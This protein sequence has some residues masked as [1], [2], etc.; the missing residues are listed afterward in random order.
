SVFNTWI[1]SEDARIVED[2]SH[3]SQIFHP[4]AHAEEHTR[5]KR[6]ADEA[7]RFASGN[8][9]TRACDRPGYTGQYCEFPICESFNPVCNPEQ[10]LGDDGYVVDLTDLGNCTD[11]HKIIVDETMFDIRIEVQSLDNVSPKLTIIDDNGYIGTPDQSIQEDDRYVAV[12][13]FIPAGPYT[14]QSSASSNNSRCILTTTAQTT[15]TISGGFQTDERDRSDFPEETAAAHQFNS[16]LLTLHGTRAPAALKTVSVVGPENYVLRPRVLNKRYGC[17]HEFYFDSL[18]CYS[19]GSYA[20]I[21]EGVDF[22]GNLFRRVAPFECVNKPLSTT[23]L[24]P[25]TPQPTNPSSCANGGVLLESGGTTTCICQDHWSGYDCSQALCV[26]G[27]TRLAGKC[28]CPIGFEEVHCEQVKCEPNSEHGFGVDRPTLVFVVRVNVHQNDILKQVQQ[29]IDEVVASLQFDP[30]YLSRFRLVIF[31]AHKIRLSR[32]YSSVNDFDWDFENQAT[33]SNDRFGQCEDG[34]LG[35][36]AAAL[37][38]TSLTQGSMI[39]VI[40]D[41]LTDDYKAQIDGIIQMN[42]FARATINFLHID[43]EASEKCEKF[44]LSDPGFRAFEDVAN[45]FGGLAWHVTD[46]KRVYD[47]L[48][49]HLNSIIYRSQ[50]ML[51]L[52][53]EE[54]GKG[55]GKVMQIESN[56]E[57][58][59]FVFTGRDFRLEMKD[60]EGMIIKP[61]TVVNEGIFTVLSWDTPLAGTY[62]ITATSDTPTA[63]CSLRAYQASPQEITHNPQTEAY[64]AISTGVEADAMMY[65]P[66]AGTENHPVF[67]IEDFGDDVDSAF[68]FLNMYAVRNGVEQEVYASNGLFRGGCTFQ[69]YFPSF[70]CRP[71]EN[72]HYEFNIRNK[73]GFYVQRAGVMTCFNYVPTPSAPT[74]CQNGGVKHNGTCLCLAHYEGEHCQ[75]LICDNGGTPLFST[76]K[77]PVGWTGQF[78][79]LPQCPECGPLPSHG[80]HVDMAF[81][82]EVSQKGVKQIEQLL[83]ILPDIIRDVVSQHPDWIDRLVLIGYDSKGVVGMVDSLISNT[84]NFFDALYTWSTSNPKDDEC[85]VQIWKAIDTLLN[86]RKDGNERR[87][88]PERS[89]V[90]II[91]ASVPNGDGDNAALIYSS[92]EELLEIRTIVNFFQSTNWNTESGKDC[93]ATKASF[94]DIERIARRG[95]GMMYMLGNGDLG[96]AMRMIPTLFSSSIV[97]KYHSN[98]CGRQVMVYFPLDAYTQTLTAIVYGQVTGYNMRKPD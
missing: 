38:D 10:F 84:A 65:Q 21:V 54:C 91:E 49:G 76:C 37:T 98:D 51:T 1:P 97:Y 94:N 40:T 85:K 11:A 16:I 15:M 72:L 79:T 90:N 5:R 93:G 77:C 50:L 39:Y 12:F 33:K 73:Q 28:F 80:Y 69:F 6:N 96:R 67:H 20:L 70:R 53:R 8:P 26:N 95:D 2:F 34:V 61:R 78:C 23:S 52:D 36:L 47:V 25:S 58:V 4:Q 48:F 24:A 89:I 17:Q 75:N 74:D 42:S 31:N 41:A 43:P 60:P 18:F 63:A 30:T 55:L 44:D 46:R 62:L 66:L 29:A 57:T 32:Q 19:T 9:I 22:F 56:A 81:L 68:A 35:A 14:I 45:R 88:L 83:G 27:G 3:L 13:K 92:S 82:V 7:A 59:V 71:N 86:G 64:W 87:A